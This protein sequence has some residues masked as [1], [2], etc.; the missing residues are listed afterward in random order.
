MTSP[1]LLLP[2]LVAALQVLR[3]KSLSI[4]LAVSAGGGL[5]WGIASPGGAI[6]SSPSRELCVPIGKFAAFDESVSRGLIESFGPA[7]EP[8][9]CFDSQSL[10]PPLEFYIWEAV[11]HPDSRLCLFRKRPVEKA[12]GQWIGLNGGRFAHT[13]YIAAKGGDGSCPATRGED[14]VGV[15][16]ISEDYLS[17]AYSL[18]REIAADPAMLYAFK[19]AANLGAPNRAWLDQVVRAVRADRNAIHSGWIAGYT[20]TAHPGGPIG[21]PQ[22][23]RLRLSFRLRDSRGGIQRFDIELIREGASYRLFSVASPN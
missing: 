7:A 10:N 20:S 18:Y 1:Y 5:F 19:G 16:G 8:E 14:P 23:D 15:A 17:E 2:K 4:L 11:P 3:L 22:P 21:T 9:V 13:L 12:N 6:A